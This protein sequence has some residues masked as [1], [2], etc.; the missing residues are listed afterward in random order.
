VMRFLDR[1][2]VLLVAVYD[3]EEI[4]IATFTQSE[5]CKLLKAYAIY[6]T[7]GE[8]VRKKSDKLSKKVLSQ[9]GQSGIMRP[10]E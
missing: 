3:K 2:S 7:F 1:K 8:I 6:T 5:Y 4:L 10:Y 9:V